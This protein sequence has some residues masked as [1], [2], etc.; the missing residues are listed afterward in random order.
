MK[1]IIFL[2][3]FCL[4]FIVVID[5]NPIHAFNLNTERSFTDT[6]MVY[7]IEEDSIVEDIIYKDSLT[8]KINDII[9][10]D[11]L[12][13]FAERL[14]VLNDQTPMGLDY[15]I[16]VQRYIDSYKGRNKAL[17]SRMQ[18]LKHLY[19]PLFEREL[20]KFKL[21]LE[22]KYLAIVESALQPKARSRS[23]ATGLWQFMYLTGVHYGLNV[24]S[25]IDDRQDPYKSTVAACKYFI[26]LYEMFGDWNLVLAAYNGGPGYL[27]RK[28]NEVG[29]YNFWDLH[30]HL[31][32][33]TRNYVPKFIATN[34]IMN[35]YQEHDIACD[36]IKRN[37][38]EIDTLTIFA[39]TTVSTLS[40]MLCLDESLIRELNPSFKEDIIPINANLF[41]PKVSVNDFLLNEVSSYIFLNG[42]ENKEI[43][44]DEERVIYSVKKGDYLGKIAKEFNVRVFELK[45]WNNLDTSHLDVGDKLV[46]YVKIHDKI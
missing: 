29:S 2:F 11:T 17:I 10:K 3:A 28:I 44:I 32:E 46:I 9:L 31:K 38:S 5:F 45:K 35:Y 7:I 12:N 16:E 19:F 4:S 14:K 34:Y 15:N 40:V 22:L 24:S 23:G 26:D 1:I 42:V 36:T 25:Y 37:F 20:D 27:Q 13:I 30:P 8:E 6:S 39:Q 18:S 33:E 41:L 21:P 43:L